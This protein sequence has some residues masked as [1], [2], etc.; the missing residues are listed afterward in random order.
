M[1]GLYC[2]LTGTA[3]AG[4]ILIGSGLDADFVFIEQGLER[5]HLR[6]T[7]HCNAIEIEALASEI[8]VDGSEN[9]SPNERVVVPLPAVIHPG[10]MSIRWSIEDSQP[11][12]RSDRW[13]VSIV[14]LAL[15]LLSSVAAGTISRIFARTG[16]AVAPSSGSSP[17]VEVAPRSAL[18]AAD[19]LT[20]AAAAERLQEEVDRAGLLNIKVGSGPGVVTTNGTLAP[21]S[22]A[23]WEEVQKW[24]DRHSNGAYTLVNAVA[25]REEKTPSSIAV[26]AVWRGSAPY[27]VIARQKYFVGA[28]LN[29]GWTVNGIEEGRVLLSRNGQVATLP[30]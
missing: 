13:R 22:R 4:P 10:T 16:S 12:R 18:N 5:H 20:T 7:P 17:V 27:L 29:N 19:A 14:A 2:G 8:R 1:S 28:L 6:V 30:Y 25:V 9:I 24:F 23:K 21:A 3:E 26:Q 11:V 15:V